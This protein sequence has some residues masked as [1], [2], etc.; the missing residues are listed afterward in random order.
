MPTEIISTIQN[1]DMPAMKNGA[2]HERNTAGILRRQERG[3][4]HDRH[5]G[6]REGNV[7]GD[8][9]E[10]VVAEALGDG[11]AAGERQHD[12]D[13]NENEGAAENVLVDGPPPLGESTTIG[14]ADHQAA[15]P[16][17]SIPLSCRTSVR[18]TSPRCS[19]FLN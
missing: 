10:A 16:W 15:S 14:A 18:N 5:R 17:L 6:H 13:E 8:E 11:G 2:D 19:K 12:A 7:A 4:D 3:R 9:V 1:H